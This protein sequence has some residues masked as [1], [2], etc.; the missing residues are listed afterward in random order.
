MNIIT[1]CLEVGNNSLN[2]IIVQEEVNILCQKK[3]LI[4][5]IIGRGSGSTLSSVRETW[6][7]DR[8]LS[9][10]LV[11]VPSNEYNFDILG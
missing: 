3:T 9:A 5:N 7:I 8:Y 10:Q 1:S 2:N 11:E 4:I 6:E